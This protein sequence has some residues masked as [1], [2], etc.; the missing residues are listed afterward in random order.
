MSLC[1]L[2]AYDVYSS[3]IHKGQKAE[4]AQMSL[5][6]WA[7]KHVVIY[8][9]NGILLSHGK[10]QGTNMYYKMDQPPQH[11][12]KWKEPVMKGHKLY[13]FVYVKHP[14]QANVSQWHGAWWLPGAEGEE[15]MGSDCCMG[16][17]LC[18]WGDENVLE[19]K[20]GGVTPHYE[21][22]KCHWIGHF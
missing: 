12:A 1:Y 18:L 5:D 16:L 3:I 7:D 13:D 20:W 19:P 14:E 17:G 8:P 15:G 10:E 9:Y 21:G 2:K 4:V 6:W 22:T 11:Y